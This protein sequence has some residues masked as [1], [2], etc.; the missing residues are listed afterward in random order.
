MF[1]LPFSIFHF[2]GMTLRFLARNVMSFIENFEVEDKKM[3]LIYILNRHLF[4]ATTTGI[5]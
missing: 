5:E 4:V 3:F 2:Y 1:H